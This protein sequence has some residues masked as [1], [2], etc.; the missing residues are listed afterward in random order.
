LPERWAGRINNASTRLTIRTLIT[1]MG[2]TRRNLPIMPIMYNRGRNAKTVVSTAIVT[3]GAISLTPFIAAS[4]L[5][6][7]RRLYVKMFSPTTIASSTTS[8]SA[9]MKAK[10]EI[11]FSEMS[12]LG[13]S[14]KAPKNDI[15]IPIVV[16][17]ASRIL[18][19][20]VRHIKTSVRPRYAFLVRRSILDRRTTELS[21]QIAIETPS[22][23]VRLFSL[24]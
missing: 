11:M 4:S 7:P 5:P 10:S 16:Q 3:G 8:P 12:N 23:S 14:Q 1:T 6:S 9:I 17:N 15:S 18:R 22:G 2:I 21:C 19:N 24:T 13:I 20:S